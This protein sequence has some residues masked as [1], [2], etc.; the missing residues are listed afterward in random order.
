MKTI[1]SRFENI[2]R[3][4]PDNVAIISGDTSLTYRQLAEA[5]DSMACTFP[6]APHRRIGIV[7]PHGAEM[8][9]AI[10]AVLKTG[11]AYIP[12]EPSFPTDRIDFI[13]Q[14][15]EADFVITAK[16]N[17]RRFKNT[18][19]YFLDAP[20]D[21]KAQ[22]D[23]QYPN[24]KPS[25]LAYVLYTSGSTGK[26]KGVMVTN[27]NVCHYADAFHHEFHNGPGDIMLQYSVCSF[28]I[29][30]EEMF[31]T[32]L[33]GATLAIPTDEEKADIRSLMK[34]VEN[35]DVTIIS[36]FPY[37]L[38]EMNKLR[39]LPSSLRLLISGGDVLRESFV[40]RLLPKVEI[41]NTYGPSETTVCASYFRCNGVKA[42][43]DG[44]FPIGKAVLGSEI[45]LLDEN[46]KLVK[47][48]EEGEICIFG[49]GV[50]NGYI[51]NRPIENEAF[52]KLEDGRRMYRSG[53]IG[54]LL[55]DGNLL[56]LHRKD[57]QVMILGKRVEPVEVQNVLCECAGIDNGVVLAHNDTQGLAYL[58]AYLVGKSDKPVD[59]DCLRECMARFLPYY[60]IPEYFVQLHEMPLTPNG[61]VDTK[62][63]PIVLKSGNL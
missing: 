30:V 56:F 13:M 8:I 53:D 31:T 59:I 24:A 19:L 32:L 40:D 61:K 29:F 44:T 54:R 4:H 17:E 9:T 23:C 49:D 25:D 39:S 14:E 33:W 1:Y 11:S 62:S 21:F 60:M 38:L 28:D 35:R 37:L 48:G 6:A 7:A 36:G 55:P 58:T 34:F 43:H 41:Y 51:G 45:V 57:T 63:L 27:A 22:T 10:L 16:A 20:N 50:S 47:D 18:T 15:C 26:P 46:L 5:V 12:V 42:Q 52:V 3:E 2:V